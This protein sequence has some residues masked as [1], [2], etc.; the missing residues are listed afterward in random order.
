MDYPFIL[1]I[2][3]TILP[4]LFYLKSIL[5]Y[6]LNRGL[7]AC[8]PKNILC[9]INTQAFSNKCIISMEIVLNRELNDLRK[10]IC[11]RISEVCDERISG[12]MSL[13]NLWSMAYT[14]C[15]APMPITS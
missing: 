6:P 15:N 1:L 7:A 5:G 13:K 12:V 10:I 4:L 3:Q 14:V 11:L 9:Q 8:S 2:E